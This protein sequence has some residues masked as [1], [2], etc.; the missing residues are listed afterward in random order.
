M[1]IQM[2]KKQRTWNLIAIYFV[3]AL[4]MGGAGL[5][6]VLAELGGAFP[7]YS[8]TAIQLVAT[9]PSIFV[10]LTN[11]ITGWLCRKFPKKYIVAIGCG[12]AVAFA[13][14][15]CFFNSSLALIYVWAA[16]LGI[17]TSLA[18]TVSP[19]IVNEMFE[20]EDRIAV[21]GIRACTTSLATM[22]M[23]FVGG[24]LVAVNWRYGFLVYL[25]MIPGLILSLVVHPKNTKLAVSEAAK[26]SAAAPFNA[27]ALVFPCLVGAAFSVL[28]CTAMVNT[29]MLVAES[30][31]VSEQLASS[32]GGLLTA[33]ILG[34]GGIM[35]FGVDGINKRIGLQS[36]TLGVILLVAGFLAFFFAKSYVVFIIGGVLCGGATLIMPH[37]QVLASAAGGMKQE[38]GLSVMLVC[39]NM[40]TLAAPLLTNLS[41]WIF[42]VEDARYR[43]LLAAM[44][45]VV[46]AAACGIYVIK[47]NKN[48][49]EPEDVRA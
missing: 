2:N 35:G 18:C 17:G 22:L 46:I 44:L 42:R 10:A 14:L 11:L 40:G 33:I 49:H 31:F 16:I 28:M 43:F 23:T 32:R 9:I 27:R 4:Q 13:L 26:A 5:S 45:G 38:L 41:K 6:P 30:G 7:Q 47:M 21:F 15:G 1:R 37:A 19:A 39:S 25:I 12:M 8:T 20:P 48:K 3:A 36:I 34:A 29:S 24:Y